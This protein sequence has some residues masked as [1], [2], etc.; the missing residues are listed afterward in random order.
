MSVAPPKPTRNSVI[1]GCENSAGS[2]PRKLKLSHRSRFVNLGKES[3]KGT[4]DESSPCIDLPSGEPPTKSQHLGQDKFDSASPA[5]SS[6]LMTNLRTKSTLQTSASILQGI[7]LTP[8]EPKSSTSTSLDT[9][10]NTARA[11]EIEYV[12]NEVFRLSA[13][14]TRY[15][16]HR[17]ETDTYFQPKLQKFPQNHMSD[18]IKDPIPLRRGKWTAEE[19]SYA[20]AVIEA[21]SAGYLDAL[22]G[23]TLRT[24]LS[25]KLQCDPMRITKKF[26]GDFSIGKK[27]F[28]PVARNEATVK[29]IE[30]TQ[31]CYHL[32]FFYHFFISYSLSLQSRSTR[33]IF[34]TI[35][36]HF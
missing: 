17:D 29:I 23:T 21:F 24:F 12:E 25:E 31:V 26:T 28:H 18:Q 20:T 27:V 6:E 4:L 22:P 16:C 19:E 36:H 10:G 3:E 33:L 7:S 1:A 11:M 13:Q 8:S 9:A 2:S 15:K 35:C 5:V 14:K 34:V 32:Q 30:E